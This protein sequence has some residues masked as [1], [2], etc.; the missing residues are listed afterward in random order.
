MITK[1]TCKMEKMFVELEKDLGSLV[2]DEEKMKKLSNNLQTLNNII[3]V[4]KQSK[5]YIQE[6]ESS[7]NE[8]H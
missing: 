2:E 1:T 5:L 8:L 4:L 7:I 6:H 3:E